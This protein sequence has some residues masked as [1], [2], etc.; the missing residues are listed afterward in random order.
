MNFYTTLN[1]S[2]QSVIGPAPTFAPG[3]IYNGLLFALYAFQANT[4]LN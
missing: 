1:T 4:T 2:F 3:A